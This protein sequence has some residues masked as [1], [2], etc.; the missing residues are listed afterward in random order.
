VIDRIE[1]RR[2][3]ATRRT[4]W[5]MVG[6]WADGLCGLGELSDV[7]PESAVAVLA[8]MIRGH[9]PDGAARWLATTGALWADASTLPEGALRR[10]TVLG[11]L[12]TAVDDLR[13]RQAGVSLAGL[14]GGEVRPI[15]L[16]ANINR[17]LRERTPA[18][19]AALAR[20]AVRDGFGAVKCAPFDRLPAGGR[21]ER[22]LEIAVAMREAIGP[23]VGLMIDVHHELSVAELVGIADGLAALDLTWLEDAAPVH[24]VRALRAVRAAVGAPL[25]GG[26]FVAH[27]GEVLPALRAGVLDVLMP[28][29]KHATG[30]AAVLRLARLAHDYGAQVSLHNPSGPVATAA[31][32]HITAVLPAGPPLELM[33]G[34]VGWRGR[35][36]SPRERVE[37]GELTLPS[38]PGLGLQL[39]TSDDAEVGD[40]ERIA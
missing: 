18:V 15:P 7:D 24:D 12:A 30:P 27:L 1:L 25:A 28:D 32:G 34:E 36:V 37:H 8:A 13:A 29:V 33:V 11:G 20:Q 17:A 19:A 31:S 22:G 38:G 35:L 2:V 4:T 23:R 21:A 14:L 9:T 5:L 6:V 40:V 3:Y 39:S 16:Y 26:E 10:H